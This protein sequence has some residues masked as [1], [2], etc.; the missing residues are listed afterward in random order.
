MY[1]Q[2]ELSTRLQNSLSHSQMQFLQILSMTNQELDR[3]LAEESLENP[4]L[5]RSEACL[6]Y[7]SLSGGK[8]LGKIV[9]ARKTVKR[10]GGLKFCRPGGCSGYEQQGISEKALKAAAF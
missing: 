8:Q 10:E 5:E 3:F 6:L 4:L 1:Y 9:K 7:T 2:T